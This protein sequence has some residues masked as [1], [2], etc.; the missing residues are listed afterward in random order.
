MG[1]QRGHFI[2]RQLNLVRLGCKDID[3]KANGVPMSSLV[4]TTETKGWHI[5]NL[6]KALRETFTKINVTLAFIT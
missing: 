5:D 1:Q 3:L 4:P 2:F 6:G